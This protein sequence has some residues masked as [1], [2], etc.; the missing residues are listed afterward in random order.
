MSSN[1]PPV[2]EGFTTI[3]PHLVVKDAGK[4][5]EFYAKAFG[6]KEIFRH[7]T[8]GGPVM[9]ARLQIG[10]SFLMINDE[11]PDMG[12]HAPETGKSGVTVHLYV[13]DVDAQVEQAVLAGAVVVFPV[14]DQFWGD[15]YGMLD[16]PFGHRWSVATCIEQLTPQQCAARAEAA[17]TQ[18]AD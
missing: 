16:D 18:G 15:R 8:P 5:I 12:V 13:E 14:A 17:F 1:V 9:H 2:P 3:T 10:N 7:Q 6:A 11:F 4:A